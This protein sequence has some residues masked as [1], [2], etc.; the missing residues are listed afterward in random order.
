MLVPTVTKGKLHVLQQYIAAWDGVAAVQLDSLFRRT[1]A[2]YVLEPNVAELHRRSLFLAGLRVGGI[3]RCAVVLVN[4]YGV[5]DLLHGYVLKRD[6]LG[7]PFSSLPRL[8]ARAVGRA[9]EVR[10]VDCYVGDS[11]L[12]VVAA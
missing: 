5:M 9:G 3:G 2:P 6:V 10:L 8:H 1:R 7:V 12:R 11:G 4:D